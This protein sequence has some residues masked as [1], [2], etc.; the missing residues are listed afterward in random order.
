MKDIVLFGTGT[1]AEV[2]E[3]YLRAHSDYRIVGYT[4]DAAF[5]R[6]ESHAGLP[7]APWEEIERHFPPDRVL[8]LG[9]LTYR[10]MNTIR[11]DRYLEGKARGYGFARFIHPGSHIYTEVIGENCVI[12]EANVIQ[13]FVEIGDNVILWTMNHIGHHSRIGDHCFIAGQAGLAGRVT[14]GPECYLAGKAGIGPGLTLGRGCALLNAARVT[15]DLP[16]LSVVDG[17]VLR[18]FPSTRLHKLI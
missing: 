16:D 2:I 5:C 17:D 18:P 4:V 8:L 14:L 13:P 3:V 7:L 12:L 9:P 6:S 11:R 1:V 10:R 15:R